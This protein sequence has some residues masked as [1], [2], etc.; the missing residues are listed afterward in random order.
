MVW[1][2]RI[3]NVIPLPRDCVAPDLHP[4]NAVGSNFRDLRLGYDL[5]PFRDVVSNARLRDWLET[6]RGELAR[7]TGQEVPRPADRAAEA[8]DALTE[9]AAEVEALGVTLTADVPADPADRSDEQQ[10]RWLLAQLLSWHR[11]ESKATSGTS[12]GESG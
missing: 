7:T 10:A 9:A 2:N 1:V 3:S 8:P 6:L 4:A 5:G 12:S 11:R